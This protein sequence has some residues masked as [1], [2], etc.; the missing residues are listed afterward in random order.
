MGEADQAAP[1]PSPLLYAVGE[2]DSRW[3]SERLEKPWSM[4]RRSSSTSTTPVACP[5]AGASP[6]A[7]REISW[8]WRTPLRSTAASFSVR[9]RGLYH[10]TAVSDRSR[11]TYAAQF[12]RRILPDRDGRLSRTVLNALSVLKQCCDSTGAIQ[13]R[14]CDTDY[15]LGFES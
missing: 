11:R 14:R 8:S 2:D 7:C 10:H 9:A 6:F 4:L 3:R 1:Q 5:E 13:E 12:I 15:T